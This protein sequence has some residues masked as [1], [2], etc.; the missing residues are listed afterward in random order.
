M[1]NFLLLLS[2]LLPVEAGAT[3]TIKF[4]LHGN[5]LTAYKHSGAGKTG[6]GYTPL[7]AIAA[8][9]EADAT[10]IGATRLNFDTGQTDIKAMMWPGFANGST[11]GKFSVLCRCS[12]SFTGAPGNLSSIF[13]ISGPP[14]VGSAGN[15]MV[16]VNLHPDGTIRLFLNNQR[17]GVLFT[18]SSFGA[19]T[20]VAGT[21]YD[22]V[23]TW[24]GTT[25][26][27]AIK[28][29][30][31]ATSF[32]NKSAGNVSTDASGN[33]V[34]GSVILGMGTSSGF[35][36]DVLVNEFV[37]WDDVIDPTS[38]GLNL[39]GASR[40]SFVSVPAP[41]DPT[42]SV[43]A[44]PG[45]IRNGTTETINGVAVTGTASIP[46]ANDVRNGTAVDAAT[47]SLIVPAA[48]SV[49]FGT[50]VD[51]TTGTAVIPVAND[52]RNGTS[53]DATAGS[54]VVPVA[55]DVRSGS[56]V[57]HTTGSLVVPSLANTAIGVSGDGG[58]GTFDGSTRW[59]CPSAGDFRSTAS[60][61]KCNST[62]PNFSGSLVVPS[63][64]NT[65]IGV[66]GDGGNGTFDGSTRW[67]CPNSAG[68]LYFG[69]TLKCNSLTAN[70]T[71]TL[72]P[73]TNTVRSAILRTN[74]GAGTD[75]I[76]L[77]QGDDASLVFYAYDEDGVA[78][79]LTGATFSTTV[80]GSS[81]TVT[82]VNAKH[83]ADADQVTNK[84]KFTLSLS[85]ADTATIK[86]EPRKE[87]VVKTV[88]SGAAKYYRGVVLKVLPLSPQ[89]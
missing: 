43:G 61:L 88:Q 77:T 16:M 14:L 12:F 25:S 74:G 84:G 15:A 70:L 72:Q 71:G 40:G 2:L 55:G 34:Q 29:Y 35:R 8:A 21:W 17:G 37:I 19:W 80:R 3:A 79:D 53:V 51:H 6:F 68:R 11:T 67:T 5:S 52:V 65:A 33:Y 18:N 87:I 75:P 50:G 54:L 66:A 1:R 27:N 39:N 76:V 83:A 36:G 10:A 78:V 44:G 9:S 63:L 13:A 47:G 22:I 31:D 49:R 89:R 69:D 58:T 7:S 82:F 4:A 56:G 59:T 85:A 60:P 45:N 62:S 41:L 81:G 57:D 42:N 46:V 26:A 24:D 28:L 30:I 86:A 23:L 38:G 64:A 73:V 20:P 32:A 48:S